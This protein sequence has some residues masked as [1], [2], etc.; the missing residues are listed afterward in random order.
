MEDTYAI[1]LE[2]ADE[3]S[4][5]ESET[6]LIPEHATKDAQIKREATV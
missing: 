3:L 5:A 6:P 2:E 4:L 1:P